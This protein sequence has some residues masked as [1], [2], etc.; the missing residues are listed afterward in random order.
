MAI[1]PSHIKDKARLETNM[2]EARHTRLRS[3]ADSINDTAR[4]AR[5]SLSLLLI[6]TLYLGLT[7]VASTDENL[8]LNGQV[9]LPQVGVGLSVAQSYIFAPPVFLYL[10]AQLLLLLTVLAQKVRTFEIALKDEFPD[11][12]PP[13]MQEKVEA[14][15]EECWDWLSAFAFVQLFRLRSDVSPVARWLAWF[16]A[17]AIPL[18]LL[19]AL[20]LSF[21]RYQSGWITLEHHIVFFID[22]AFLRWFNRKVFGG[23]G[24]GFSTVLIGSSQGHPPRAERRSW[25]ILRRVINT[26]WGIVVYGIAL[27]LLLAAR[28]P[29][30]DP[31]TVEK[32]RESI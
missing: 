6:V 23:W 25:E 16:G 3:L 11:T 20:D 28:P 8:L 10:H 15:R 22:W 27:F 9:V 17:E 30:F 7:L 1:R 12:A 5:N 26:A 14:R 24:L 18:T 32:D 19:L 31:E 13:N 4:M 29:S 2:R 21:V